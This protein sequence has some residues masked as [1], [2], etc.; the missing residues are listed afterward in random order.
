MIGNRALPHLPF[1]SSG[2]SFLTLPTSFE[3]SKASISSA[4][5][6]AAG[7]PAAEPG[8]NRARAS[9]HSRRAGSAGDCRPMPIKPTSPYQFKE[10]LVR[11]PCPPR[12]YPLIHPHR[13]CTVVYPATSLRSPK[14]SPCR[15]Q[16]LQDDQASS[17]QTRPGRL[18]WQLPVRKCQELS[19]ARARRATETFALD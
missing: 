3:T 4:D 17:R 2:E 7:Q 15:R 10:R 5:R 14:G 9:G 8:R 19:H 12:Q 13:V 11:L 18:D 6:G 16:L 1:N